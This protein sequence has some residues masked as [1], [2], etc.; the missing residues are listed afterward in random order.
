MADETPKPEL[1][2]AEQAHRQLVRLLSSRG[3]PVKK[4]KKVEKSSTWPF[5]GG[6]WS[7]PQ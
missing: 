7:P 6:R 3:K 5:K 1:P 2:R 4:A